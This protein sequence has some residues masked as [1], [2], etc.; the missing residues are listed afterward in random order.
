MKVRD[1][2]VTVTWFG[3]THHRH[4]SNPPVAGR[5]I[6]DAIYFLGSNCVSPALAQAVAAVER[7]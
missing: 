5:T 3:D 6:T 2:G 7:D 1:W 4:S